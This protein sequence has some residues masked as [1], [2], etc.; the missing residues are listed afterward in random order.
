MTSSKKKK[1]KKIR[2]EVEEKRARVWDKES[3]CMCLRA[4]ARARERKCVYIMHAWWRGKKAGGNPHTIIPK[5][6][7][8]TR[9][10]E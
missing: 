3:V 2:E 10:V 7:E 1:T 6:K 4:R 8:R 5:R 9:H